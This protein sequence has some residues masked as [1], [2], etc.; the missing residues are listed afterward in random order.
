MLEQQGLLFIGAF[1][2]EILD[3]V[4]HNPIFVVFLGADTGLISD[5]NIILRQP[6]FIYKVLVWTLSESSL[7]LIMS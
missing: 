3:K 4:Q 7:M 1:I 6:Y 2:I 5:I